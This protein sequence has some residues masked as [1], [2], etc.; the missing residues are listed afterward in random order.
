M[1]KLLAT[2]GLDDKARA[3]IL[4]LRTWLVPQVAENGKP[5]GS[6]GCESYASCSG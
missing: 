5:S 4:A 1:K 2:P 6:L 3:A